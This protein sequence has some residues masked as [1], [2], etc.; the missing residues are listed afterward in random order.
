VV[1]RWSGD[2]NFMSVI[3]EVRT[4]PDALDRTFAL[5]KAELQASIA[6]IGPARG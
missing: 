2:T 4:I 5:Y 1:P 3:G 6:R